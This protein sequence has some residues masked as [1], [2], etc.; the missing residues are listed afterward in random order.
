M[1]LSSPPTMIV[2]VL[3][4]PVAVG[5]PDRLSAVSGV[6]KGREART[7][8]AACGCAAFRSSG[9]LGRR[10]SRGLGRRGRRRRPTSSKGFKG[11]KGTFVGRFGGV[12]GKH[13]PALTVLANTAVEPTRASI[14]IV[15]KSKLMYKRCGNVGGHPIF[16][17]STNI[18]FLTAKRPTCR[19]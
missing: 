16:S 8:S 15:W 1:R 6:C 14:V 18:P 9:G 10:C 3:G 7:R 17:I 19:R 11:L 12:D 5:A 4:S 2:C 13:H